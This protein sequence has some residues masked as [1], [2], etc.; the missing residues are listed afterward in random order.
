VALVAV[1][2]TRPAAAVQATCD[3]GE[4]RSGENRVQD[5][6]QRF[7]ALRQAC[8]ALRLHIIGGLQTNKARS[9]CAR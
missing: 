7:P 6:A 1:S 9:R 5:A 2:K 4:P 8:P 3:A